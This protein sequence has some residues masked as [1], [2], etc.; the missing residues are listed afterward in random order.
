MGRKQKRPAAAKTAGKQQH[1]FALGDVHGELDGML[2]MLLHAGLVDGK[3][4]WKGGKKIFVQ[5]GDIVDRGP[6]PLES[7]RFLSRFQQGAAKAGGKVVRLLGNHELEILRGNFAVTTL[8][9]SRAADYRAQLID[10]IK[11][12]A[13]TAAF[14]G[15]GYLFTHAGLTGAMQD[16]VSAGKNFGRPKNTEAAFA[17]VLNA[18]LMKA[19]T[20]GDY[21]HPIFNVGYSRGG[22]DRN[23]GI[24]WED[25]RELFADEKADRIK[26]IFGH[27]PLKKIVISESGRLAAIDVGLYKGYGGGRSYVELKSGRPPVCVDF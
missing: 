2:A 22:N 13:I 12:S 6:Y 15:G 26:Q 11:S 9:P 8:P 17:S 10:E 1:I 14:A 3:G 24:F 7:G 16:I 21:G 4:L 20:D 27:T 19:V 5:I 18:I 25:V 23:G